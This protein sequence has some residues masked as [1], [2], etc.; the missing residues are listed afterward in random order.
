MAKVLFRAIRTR[1]GYPNFGNM[2]KEVERT[3]DAVVK[4]RLLTYFTRITDLWEHK[5][6]FQA[7]KTVRPEGITLYV[8]PTGPNKK[9]WLWTSRGTKPHIIKPKAAGYPLQ[10]RTD[11]KPRTRPGYRYRG[12]GKAVGPWVSAYEVHHPGTKPREFEKHIRRFYQPKFRKEMENALRRGA[13]K[14]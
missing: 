6:D 1:S 14:L 2:T 3:I 4:P 7:R 10:F 9:L 13:R 8:Y 12:P 11:Y 5:V